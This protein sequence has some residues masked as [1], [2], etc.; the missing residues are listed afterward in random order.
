MDLS[1]K[2]LVH[3]TLKRAPSFQFL[4]EIVGPWQA[5][6]RP[7]HRLQSDHAPA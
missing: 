4:I 3:K 7:A 1:R 2:I 5:H 6:H